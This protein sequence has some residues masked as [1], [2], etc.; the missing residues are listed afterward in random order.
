VNLG[1]L[2]GTFS[3]GAGQLRRWLVRNASSEPAAGL[4]PCASMSLM[5]TRSPTAS[6]PHPARALGSQYAEPAGD[7]AVPL[8]PLHK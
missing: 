5:R 3:C 8:N 7:D 4:P 2:F 1:V 6:T